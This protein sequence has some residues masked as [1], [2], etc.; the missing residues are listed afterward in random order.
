MRSWGPG[1]GYTLTS[2]RPRTLNTEPHFSSCRWRPL[3]REA[4]GTP[5][6]QGR[7]SCLPIA[8]SPP[9]D[10]TPNPLG[11]AGRVLPLPS[12]WKVAVTEAL[13]ASSAHEAAL[14]MPRA[15]VVGQQPGDT[16]VLWTL[17]AKAGPYSG[18]REPRMG[19]A[20]GQPVWTRARDPG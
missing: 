18:V 12:A 16:W 20:Q 1:A 6:S 17:W 4:A 13:T 2:R 10:K 15:T 11:F 19:Q 5:A 9:R 7:A 8:T 3:R 14:R